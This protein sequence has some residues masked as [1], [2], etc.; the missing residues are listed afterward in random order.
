VGAGPFLLQ[1]WNKGSDATFVRN[2]GY[3]DPALPYLDTIHVSL[4]VDENTQVLRLQ[5]GDADAVFE[6]FSISPASLRLLKTDPTLTVS[7]SV[8]PRIYYLALENGGLFG[9]K[10]LRLAVAHAVTTGFL[11]QFGDLAKPWNQLMGSATKQSD[12]EGTRVYPYDPEKAKAYLA[13]GGY[14]GTP[15]KIIYDVTDPYQAANS[16]ALKQDLEAVGFTVDLQGL[17]SAEFFGGAVY[18][19]AKRDISSTYWSADYPDAQDYFSTNF[20]CDSILNI[21]HF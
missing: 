20:T 5:S 16:T 17:Q 4:N 8:G 10:D 18:D 21:S 9:N 13:S 6:S 2:P 1:S 14:D 15:V 11:D 7:P 19:P 12:P 3:V